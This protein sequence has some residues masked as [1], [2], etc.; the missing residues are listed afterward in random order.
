MEYITRVAQHYPTTVI[1]NQNTFIPSRI[2]APPPPTSAPHPPTSAPYANPCSSN[3][4][5]TIDN[6]IDAFFGR[7]PSTLLNHPKITPPNPSPSF[8]NPKTNSPPLLSKE[9]PILPPTPV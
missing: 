8:Q 1:R 6:P 5:L 9:I 7:S 4:R 2:P 3:T